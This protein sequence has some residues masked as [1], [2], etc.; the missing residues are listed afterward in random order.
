MRSTE[1]LVF[2]VFCF[3]ATA[4]CSLRKDADYW[5][6][7]ATDELEEALNVKR[8]VNRAKNVILF[9]GDGMGPSTVTATRIY[10]GGESFKLAYETFPHVGLLKTY[11]ADKM[12]PDSASTATALLCGVKVN[13]Y[14]VGVDSTVKHKDCAAS[15]N[16]KAHL[17]SLAALALKAGKSAGFVTTMRVTHA[18][19]GPLYAHCATRA[20]ECD[21]DMPAEA[22]N[23]KDIARQ[24]V[25]DWPGRDLNVIMGGGRQGL[26][27]NSTGTPTDP[28]SSWACSRRDGRNLIGEYKKDKE[29]RRLKYS[30]VSNTRE[31][32][33]FNTTDYL[34][35]IFANEHLRY[36]SE[37]NKAADGMP[38]ISEMTE[39][40]IKVL[41]RNSNGFFLMIEG[42][43]I[44][45]AHH[46]GRAKVAINESSA[47][48]D[49]VRLA[50]SM[51]DE[52]DTL[53]VV[54]SDHAHALQ[55]NGYPDRGSNLFG[56]IGPSKHDGLN[57]TILSYGTGGPGSFQYTVETN[58]N[59]SHVV[60]Q[61]PSKVDT[62]S[63]K[64]EQIAAIPLD[65]NIHG[66]VDVAVYARGPYAHL[67]HN[68]HEQNYVYH[69]IS[70]AAS[71]GPY[72]T[73]H[74]LQINVAIYLTT[75]LTLVG[76]S[77]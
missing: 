24:L 32:R 8:N 30:V 19:P 65:E 35:G 14:T 66:G 73:G 29:A 63:F 40:A 45:M 42:G 3:I 10:K 67:F 49:A 61:D 60:R 20:W 58:E 74:A 64:Y 54:T 31:L 2:L 51:T 18:T 75:L 68:V 25:E 7:L 69:V 34:L 76:F 62:N 37:R 43:N 41:Q 26:T 48:D 17:D 38:S 33:E 11:S 28:T 52:R 77:V 56:S 55:I 9:I 59:G 23:C 47:M 4:R 50:V 36:E 6:K 44:D 46:R 21:G 72:S 71:I 16:P 70:Y 22:E 57:Y 12:V 27:P 53:I 15:L 13:Q 39:A 5:T 1:V